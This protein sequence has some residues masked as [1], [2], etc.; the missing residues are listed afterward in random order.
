MTIIEKVV[1][2]GSARRR[3]TARLLCLGSAKR[4]LVWMNSTI[5]SEASHVSE[6]ALCLC[7][8]CL[9]ARRA[10][11][12]AV[13]P[14]P[15]SGAKSLFVLN[16]TVQWMSTVSPEIEDEGLQHKGTVTQDSGKI[17]LSVVLSRASV[18]GLHDLS[19]RRCLFLVLLLL[20]LNGH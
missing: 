5:T 12:S 17:K 16:V 18:I 7:E 11:E 19:D 8:S 14:V 4:K 2:C 3:S 13:L 6:E 15:G 20:L 1:L 9:H 10:R